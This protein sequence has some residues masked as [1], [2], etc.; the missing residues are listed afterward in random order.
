MPPLI[1]PFLPIGAAPEVPTLPRADEYA[2]PLLEA[3][4]DVE[5]ARLPCPGW[6]ALADLS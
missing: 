3:T 6:P 1:D 4:L 5:G 2:V